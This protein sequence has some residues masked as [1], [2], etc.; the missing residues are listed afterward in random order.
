MTVNDGGLPGL[1]VPSPWQ[2]VG[3]SLSIVVALLLV[4]ALGVR[5]AT[6]LDPRQ[7]WIPVALVF[8]IAAADL[9]SGLV[10]WGADTWGR[11]DLPVV[12][13]RLLRP[14][15]LHHLNP[16]DFLRRR[17]TD[18]NGDIAS[19]AVPV[20]LSL[21]AIPVE[22]GVGGPVAVFG[23]TFCGV[24][25]MTNQI[26]QWAHMPAPP[27]PIRRLQDWGLLLGRSHHA[28]HH[29]RPYAVNYCITTGWCNRLIEALGLFR[30]L[31]AVITRLTG[32]QPRF[33]DGRYGEQYGDGRPGDSRHG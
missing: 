14:F 25:M 32:A 21:L 11:D 12:G 29:D 26:H 20:L 30:R 31:E 6:R 18:T 3:W 33:D 24:G 5:I 1:E 16:D 23:L 27:L 9:L 4:A 10:H 17:F 7:W 19:L 2:R 13:R 8:G 22:S 15:R 28:V